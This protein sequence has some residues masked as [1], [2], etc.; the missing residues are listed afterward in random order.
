MILS[1]LARP[2]RAKRK[3][4]LLR[5]M[6]DST[7]ADIHWLTSPA[8]QEALAELANP[9]DA[10][11]KLA[12]Q[13]AA[14]LR[15][16]H[17]AART[18]LLLEQ[19]ELRWRAR[20]KFLRSSELYYTRKGLE[21][22]SDEFVAR[23]KAG[24]FPHAGAVA[25]LCCG[26]GG[27]LLQLATRGP[28]V[29]YEADAATA[30]I[31]AA[32]LSGRG[33]AGSTVRNEFAGIAAVEQVA[34]W[35]I[36]P[37]RRATGTRVVE[38][39]DYEPGPDV[40]HALLRANPNG[41]VKLAPA[42]LLGPADWPPC[43]REW[44]GSR[45]ECRQQ[46]LWFGNLVQRMGKHTATEVKADFS[47]HSFSGSPE[48]PFQYAERV[49]DFLY[50]P[51]ATMLAARLAGALAAEQELQSITPGGGYLTSSRFIS[52]GLLDAFRV[53][54]VLIF[55]QRKLR[56]YCRERTIGRLDVKKR[57]VDIDPARVRREI[58]AAGDDSAVIFVTKIAGNV[59]A[60]VAERCRESFDT[61]T[62]APGL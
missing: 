28:T 62:A 17:S 41:A 36:D 61:L 45:G 31:A 51:S 3:L 49:E 32:N 15:K 46:V 54:D 27:D 13:A 9:S 26:I 56:A 18:H 4:E 40:L 38:I 58:I 44:L 59:R 35:H 2:F 8:G 29:G 37:D 6:T 7:L 14:R 48:M 53:R 24:R 19:R 21:Q 34:A 20:D 5:C 55:D 11:K 52:H 30:Y 39:D 42:A 60:I 47:C 22:A 10:G 50:E 25:D 12:V 23:V 16:K 33:L 57:G 43:E 1:C